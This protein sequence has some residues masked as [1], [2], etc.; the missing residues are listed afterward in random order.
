MQPECAVLE[1]SAAG[2]FFNR[3]PQ[4]NS[5]AN[6]LL[7]SLQQHTSAL[8]STVAELR[9]D[10]RWLHAELQQ[11]RAALQVSDKSSAVAQSR[12][13]KTLEVMHAKAYQTEEQIEALS[14]AFVDFLHSIAHG[15]TPA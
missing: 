3:R 15:T 12:M 13:D 10:N 5:V 1:E 4:D 6:D 14:D 7:L 11:M 2:N 8:S 9:E